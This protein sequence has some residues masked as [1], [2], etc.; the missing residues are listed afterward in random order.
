[1]L[2]LT[3]VAV[4]L[5]NTIVFFMNQKLA[6]AV[7]SHAVDAAKTLVQMPKKLK[8]CSGVSAC[9]A[10]N[11]SCSSSIA[12][13]EKLCSDENACVVCYTNP[14]TGKK[15]YYSFNATLVGKGKD[16]LVYEVRL[17]WKLNKEKVEKPV[18]ITVTNSTRKH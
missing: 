2:I 8:K 17:C 10:F 15:F 7:A 11:A 18:L 13:D 16:Y 5:L 9:S 1:M 3:L 12:C 4:A 14:S 6:T